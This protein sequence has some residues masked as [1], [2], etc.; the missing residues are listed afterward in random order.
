MILTIVD[1]D[2]TATMRLVRCFERLEVMILPKLLGLRVM[3]N[4]PSLSLSEKLTGACQIYL[5]VLSGF[6]ESSLP[7]VQSS[8]RGAWWL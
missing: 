7:V 6:A 4:Y 1:G 2:I 3:R 8:E 5:G